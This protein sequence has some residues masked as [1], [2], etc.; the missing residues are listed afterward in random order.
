MSVSWYSLISES[1]E[2]PGLRSS[3]DGGVT[4]VI[5]WDSDRGW[6]QNVIL[7]FDYNWE[8]HFHANLFRTSLQL[9]LKTCIFETQFIMTYTKPYPRMILW[10]EFMIILLK[11]TLNERFGGFHY[12]VWPRKIKNSIQRNCRS[13][14]LHPTSAIFYMYTPIIC[15]CILTWTRHAKR[16]K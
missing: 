2:T 14:L 9:E 5:F 6:R 12:R 16:F 11:K 4:G 15:T 7:S 3:W 10:T 13:T 8:I 1:S